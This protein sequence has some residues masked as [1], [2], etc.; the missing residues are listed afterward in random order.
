MEEA[1][2]TVAPR[3]GNDVAAP[4][5]ATCCDGPPP[6]YTGLRGCDPRIPFQK[7]WTMQVRCP[8]CHTPIEL[9]SDGSLSEINCPSCGSSF[10]LLG[11]DTV[12]Y[13]PGK[14]QTI[15]HFELIEQI[16]SGTFGSVWRARDIDLDRV[17]AIKIPRK[18]QLSTGETEQLLREARATAQ[19][20][21]AGIVTVH[22][23]GRDDETVY[24][25]SDLVQGV[26]LEDARGMSGDRLF[27]NQE[28]Q[29]PPVW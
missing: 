24:I 29:T 28:M 23:V 3:V 21:H 18:G 10:S 12:P 26:T 27:G 11:E 2:Q 8:Q 19:L 16:G 14:T 6:K 13:E 9:A 15:G 22:E 4:S 20:R 25:V 17:V 1:E 5:S 7:G